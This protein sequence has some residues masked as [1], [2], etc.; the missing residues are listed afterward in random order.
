MEPFWTLL[1]L[2][3]APALPHWELLHQPVLPIRADPPKPRRK[4]LTS[5]E[6]DAVIQSIPLESADYQPLLRFSPAVPTTNT[7]P[8]NQ[9]SM[10]FSNISPFD[11]GVAGGTGNQN[12]AVNLDVGLDKNLML[13]FFVSQA[14][15]PLSERIKDFVNPISNFWQSYGAAFRWRWL[16]D[17]SWSAAFNGSLEVWEVR[18]G[19][20]VAF[21]S[22]AAS[23]NNI[24]NDSGSFVFTR[25]LVGSLSLPLSWQPSSTWQFTFAPGVSFLPANQGT[26]QGGAGEF[27][28]NNPFISAGILVQPTPEFGFTTSVL[29]PVGIG[30]NSFDADLVFSRVPI[31]SAGLKWDLNPR[32]GLRGLL[33]NGFGATPATALLT[34]PSSN[35]LGY[36]FSFVFTPDAPDTP[37]VPLSKRQSLL[38]LGG[39]T[40]NTALVPPDDES[41]IWMNL[42]SNGNIS[43]FF[44]YSLSNI[45]QLQL[46]GTFYRNTYQALPQTSDGFFSWRVGGK[47]VVLSPLRGAPFWAGGRVTLGRNNDLFN[48]AGQDNIGQGYVFS[49]TMATWELSSNFALSVNPKLV[50]GNA[51]QLWGVGVGS[52]FQLAPFWQLIAEGN[53][54]FS[55]LRKPGM[56]TVDSDILMKASFQNN[57]T[58]GL[59][60]QVKEGLFIDFFGTSSASLLDAGQLLTA[61]KMRWGFRAV[62][63]F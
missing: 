3:E 14:D 43:S 16:R 37:Q 32:I 35:R 4:S 45:F 39:F 13:S 11:P 26:S 50:I 25:N 21:T 61:T 31:I 12:Y 22:S 2:F 41:N 33:T 62:G 6:F 53:L 18:S 24:F 8:P 60:W 52:N 38:G 48:N 55:K 34:L 5:E 57:G 28:G 56:L 58:L 15:D 10:Q 27:Y 42:G 19:G 49:E 17:E 23:G 63:R 7:L 46:G 44:G 47:A 51:G 1:Q 36:D 54:V 29:F 9:W 30:T 20:N 59:R 40:V